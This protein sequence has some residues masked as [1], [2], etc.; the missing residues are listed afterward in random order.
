[1]RLNWMHFQYCRSMWILCN[2]WSQRFV[3][4]SFVFGF[5]F[6]L[7]GEPTRARSVSV[8]HQQHI[9][10]ICGIC[11]HEIPCEKTVSPPPFSVFVLWP[12]L[13]L[14]VFRG[15]HAECTE[16]VAWTT[17]V[18]GVAG[19][20]TIHPIIRSI[21]Y[22]TNILLLQRQLNFGPSDRLASPLPFTTTR[23]KKKTFGTWLTSI[24]S[25]L[26]SMSNWGS[27]KRCVRSAQRY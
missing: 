23:E 24:D 21:R 1:M 22:E 11:G 12:L 20:R 17:G 5:L 3:P 27:L 8:K 15:A 18:F 7:S 10:Y 19:Y 6:L 14:T 9:S 13:C 2:C 26:V 25:I 4:Y 16:C